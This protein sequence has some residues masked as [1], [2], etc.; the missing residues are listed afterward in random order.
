M[1]K[2]REHWGTRAGFIL[3]A[4]GSAIGLG[5]IWRFPYVAYENGGGAFLL[6]YLIALLTAGIPLLL[7]EYSL[8]H[9]S[10]ASAPIAYRRL[11]KAAEGIGW[12]QVGVA[13]VLAAYY[14]VIIGWAAR[15]AGFSITQTWAD[16][17]DGTE[18]FFFNR[19]LQI[20]EGYWDFAWTENG[21]WVGGVG[22]PLVGIW[23]IVFIALFAGVRRGIEMVNRI[24]IPLLV[25]LF[26][27]LVVRAVTLEGSG[28]GLN[29]FFTPD[30]GALTNPTVWIAAYAQIFFSLS[31][32]FGI[33]IAYASYL[34]RKSDLT[35][36]ALTVGFANSSFELLAGIGVFAILGYM[37]FQSGTPVDE[38][39]TG[40]IGLA[41]VAFPEIVSA[42][43]WGSAFFG[44]LFF[45][46]LVL[47]GLSSLISIVQVPVAAAQDRLGWSRQK[48]VITIVGGIGAAAVL[49]M[50]MTNGLYVLDAADGAIE[51][52]GIALAALVSI[53]AVAWIARKLP[54]LRDHANRW[55]SIKLGWAWMI[56][57]GLITPLFLMYMLFQATRER[58]GIVANREEGWELLRFGFIIA[59]GLIA[60]A[61]VM[62]ILSR[63]I[64]LP[65]GME[66]DAT[67]NDHD[68][69]G[70]ADTASVS[71]GGD[72]ED[73]NDTSEEAK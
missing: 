59:F 16:N 43:P 29:A 71:A 49:F 19:V 55:S 54:Q 18:D 40:S 12:W 4:A 15:Y 73:S 20:S 33:M 70:D 9:R 46:C 32:G 3:A 35:G 13:V 52:F 26:G 23:V 69:N 63:F 22:W 66:D 1:L 45:A 64:K 61:I 57:L 31:I 56:S 5:N 50:P 7:M 8:G 10:K 67:G 27:I 41:F 53:I 28:A 24:A 60:F 14:S 47:A 51:N 65:E 58:F 72:D 21:T 48:S 44:F 25:V 42:L 17:P 11:F 37:A 36:S 6:P 34:R 39:V 30:F 38:Q 62:T 2:Q 68:L